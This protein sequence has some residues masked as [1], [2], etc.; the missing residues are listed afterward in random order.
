MDIIEMFKLGM[1]RDIKPL[2]T[3]DMTNAI[4]LGAGKNPIPGARS[5]DFPQWD[6]DWGCL[7]ETEKKLTAVFAFH[8][9]EHIT[10]ESAI[11]LLRDIQK[12]MVPGGTVNIVVPHAKSD[13]WLHDL[14]H[15]SFYVTDTWETLF[16]TPYYDKNREEPWLFD[17]GTNIV[18]AVTERNTALMTQLVRK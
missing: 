10:G 16:S 1:K 3:P 13:L 11:A 5:L 8:F 7:P 12:K 18:I 6:A 14:D 15:K 4:N 2:V 9:F 17:I